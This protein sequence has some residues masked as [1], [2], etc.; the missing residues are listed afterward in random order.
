[1]FEY[2]SSFKITKKNAERISQ[3]GRIRWKIENSFNQQKNH[4]YNLGHLFSEVSLKA[5]KNYYQSMQIADMIN[6]LLVLGQ[7]LKSYLKKKI[8]IKHLWTELLAFL[9]YRY[10]DKENLKILLSTRIQIRLE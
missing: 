9:K 1:M 2:I 4:G 7:N 5:F 10:I 8:T 3:A 6:Q